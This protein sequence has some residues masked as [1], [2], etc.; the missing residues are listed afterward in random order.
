MHAALVFSIAAADPCPADVV[1]T[2]SEYVVDEEAGMLG[3]SLSAGLNEL[4]PTDDVVATI[5]LS[6]GGDGEALATPFGGQG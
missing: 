5:A 1:F 3:I 2:M 4:A 6:Q